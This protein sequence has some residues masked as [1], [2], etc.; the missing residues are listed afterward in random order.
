LTCR[1]VSPGSSTPWR[2]RWWT[3]WSPTA[4]SPSLP[5]DTNSN[6][7]IAKL[8]YR[9]QAEVAGGKQVRVLRL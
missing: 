4:P 8:I 6:L 7:A 1:A 3:S 9:E 5:R 2:R